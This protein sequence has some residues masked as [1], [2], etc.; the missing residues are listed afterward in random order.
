MPGSSPNNRRNRFDGRTQEPRLNALPQYQPLP[1]LDNLAA[2][3]AGR[4][5]LGEVP[6]G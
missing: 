4:P 3:F 1:L 5:I 2:Y 6:L